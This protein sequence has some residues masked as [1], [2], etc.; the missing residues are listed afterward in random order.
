MNYSERW[1]TPLDRVSASFKNEFG[2]L[3][4]QE[5]NFKPYAQTWSIGQIMDHLIV[6]NESYYPIIKKLKD[7]TY[8]IPWHGKINFLT[9]LFGKIILDS[10]M[11]GAKRKTK[12]FPVWQPTSSTIPPDITARLLKHNEELK[13]L[14]NSS[15][16]LVEKGAVISSPANK[17]IVYKLETAYDILIAHEERHFLQAVALKKILPA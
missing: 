15:L 11:P 7:N 10:V 9:K 14:I 12:T 16:S 8:T 6:I 1:S 17:N 4:E 3:T 2:N 13:H 5:L